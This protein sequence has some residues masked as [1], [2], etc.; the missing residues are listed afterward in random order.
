M[1]HTYADGRADA[2]YHAAEI[3]EEML[4]EEGKSPELIASVFKSIA[5]DS[6]RY[7]DRVN[8]GYPQQGAG[9]HSEH[10]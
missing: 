3:L 7:A 8:S 4:F 1:S 10:G 2:W 5:A 6:R 9:Q